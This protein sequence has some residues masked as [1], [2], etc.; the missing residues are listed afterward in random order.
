M[1]IAPHQGL[2][3]CLGDA[4]KLLLLS[5]E[6]RSLLARVLIILTVEM[7]IRLLGDCEV[8]STQTL[9]LAACI[10]SRLP[11]HLFSCSNSGCVGILLLEFVSS[12]CGSFLAFLYFPFLFVLGVYLFNLFPFY[13]FLM[14]LV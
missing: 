6:K 5:V 9:F 1:Y 10:C 14:F 4:S 3:S 7:H 11:I 8:G 13:Q 2:F 12:Y